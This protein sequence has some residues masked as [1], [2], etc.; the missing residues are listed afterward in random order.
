MVKCTILLLCVLCNL[1]LLGKIIQQQRLLPKLLPVFN[2]TWAPL[3]STTSTFQLS[4]AE[5]ACYFTE[6]PGDRFP[7][8]H[9]FLLPSHHNAGTILS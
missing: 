7:M 5:F 6:T 8:H 3:N 2:T 4:V 9:Y 1:V